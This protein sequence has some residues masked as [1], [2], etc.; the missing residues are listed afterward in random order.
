M[1]KK[2]KLELA[3]MK[4]MGLRSGV[5][6]DSRNIEWDDFF[7]TELV[8]R[9]MTDKEI[10]EIDFYDLC[11]CAALWMTDKDKIPLTPVALVY[12]REYQAQM[13]QGKKTEI[14]S[15]LHVVGYRASSGMVVK[16]IVPENG[17]PS[18]SLE[19]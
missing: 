18:I 14:T 5:T 13:T 6:L 15:I 10:L 16:L 1:N 4:W 2:T 8:I 7:E 11:G 9:K 12:Y 17:T 3:V 19:N